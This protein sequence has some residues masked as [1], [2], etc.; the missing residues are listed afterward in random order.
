MKQVIIII[1][2]NF[3]FKTKQAL[4]ENRFFA[5]STKEVL[6]RGKVRVHFTAGEAGKD[7]VTDEVY[8]NALVAK[9]MIEMVVPDDDVERLVEIILSVNSHGVDGDGK[10]F[11][12]PVEE[13]IRIHTGETGEDALM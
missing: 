10:I 2:P 7:E 4:S 3:Y 13:S 12:Q 5:M 11:I 8:E 6:G 9:K 1:R